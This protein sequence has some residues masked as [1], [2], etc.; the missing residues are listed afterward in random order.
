MQP[1]NVL[2]SDPPWAYRDKASAGKRGASYKYEVMD[3]DTIKALPVV[4]LV[5]ENSICYLWATGPFLPDAIDVLDSWGFCFKTIGFCWV[6][7]NTNSGKLAWGMGH[8]TRANVELVLLGVRGK[9]VEVVNHG[10]HQVVQ[11]PRRKHSAKPDEV[12]AC[13]ERLHG[14]DIRRVELF[15]RRRRK[16]WHC[17][18]N[19]IPGGGDINLVDGIWQLDEGVNEELP[20]INT[21]PAKEIDLMDWLYDL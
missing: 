4:D 7:K 2:I 15:A 11:S 6:K 20:S 18:G 16:G 3:L 1:Y 10:I 8:Y 13:I 14:P 5:T 21:H 9:G 19:E 12:Q 17:F